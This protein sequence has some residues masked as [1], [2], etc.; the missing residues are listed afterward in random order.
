MPEINP[1]T[2]AL[3][4][5]VAAVLVQ[6]F[7][8]ALPEIAQR[9]LPLILMVVL[10]PLGVGLAVYYGNDPLA[11]A[12]EGFLAFASSVGFYQTAK[13]IIPGAVNGE[14]WVKFG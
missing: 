11:G 10:T 1:A 6:V 5:S 3:L 14:G 4:A 7:K 9:W 13:T 12:F 8:G 2:V